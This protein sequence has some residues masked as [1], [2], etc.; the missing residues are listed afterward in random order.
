MVSK[1]NIRGFID[2]IKER[3]DIKS[4]GTILNLIHYY[5]GEVT[6]RDKDDVRNK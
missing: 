2:A 4:K 1:R 5:M 6:Q 3:P